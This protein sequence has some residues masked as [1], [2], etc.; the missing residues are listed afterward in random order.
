TEL[1]MPKRPYAGLFGGFIWSHIKRA[2]I[3]HFVA[4]CL[5]QLETQGEL[6]FIDNR[7][8]AGSSTPI[9]RVDVQGNQYQ[10][11]KLK[12]GEAFEVVKNFPSQA[13]FAHL[14]GVQLGQFEWVELDYYW[15]AKFVKGGN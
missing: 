11:R 1:L 4:T 9:S 13:E 15:I 14:I 2:D 6:I 8:F 5:S 10:I 12:S 7:Y 3:L